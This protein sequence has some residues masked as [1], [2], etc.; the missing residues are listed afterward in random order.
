[1]VSYRVYLALIAAIDIVMLFVYGG[2]V[3]IEKLTD[4]HTNLVYE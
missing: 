4:V 1:M 2:N 3:A